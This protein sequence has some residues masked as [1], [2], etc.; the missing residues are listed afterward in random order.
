MSLGKRWYIRDHINGQPQQLWLFDFD[1]QTATPSLYL[2]KTFDHGLGIA[3]LSELS[4][5]GPCDHSSVLRVSAGS[6]NAVIGSR[7]LIGRAWSCRNP[8]GRHA[9]VDHQRKPAAQFLQ[10]GVATGAK[11]HSV[12]RTHHQRER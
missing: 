6:G 2:L 7:A 5:S 9:S 3:P 10:Q 12:R 11:L 8:F 1:N 4:E